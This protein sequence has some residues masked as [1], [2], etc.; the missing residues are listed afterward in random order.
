LQHLGKLLF[1]FK[2]FACNITGPEPDPDQNFYPE[3]G[4]MIAI[5]GDEKR[6]FLFTISCLKSN[7]QYIGQMNQNFMVT[8]SL[9]KGPQ[10]W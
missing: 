1:V 7:V 10:Y 3:P 9:R 2:R 5:K 6:Y 4:L 8:V